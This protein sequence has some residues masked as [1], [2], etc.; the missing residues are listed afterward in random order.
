MRIDLK[1][2]FPW[3]VAGYQKLIQLLSHW[4][5]CTYSHIWIAASKLWQT[6]NAIF[7]QQSVNIPLKSAEMPLLISNWTGLDSWISLQ[8]TVVSSFC[9]IFDK[10]RYHQQELLHQKWDS[11]SESGKNGHTWITVDPTCWMWDWILKEQKVVWQIRRQ[12]NVFKLWA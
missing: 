1:S 7:M 10:E 11:R 12:E 2:P 4:S 6:G 9:Y 8:T 3:L 5:V